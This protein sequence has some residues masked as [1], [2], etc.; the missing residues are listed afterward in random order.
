MSITETTF[1]WPDVTGP[2]ARAVY[3]A[4]ADICIKQQAVPWNI[5]IASSDPFA[6]VS[7]L[8]SADGALG[9]GDVDRVAAVLD[10]ADD[11]GESSNYTRQGASVLAGVPV[12][13]NVYTARVASVQS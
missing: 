1:L 9:I 4:I 7:V 8:I 5:D 2:E 13:L 12:T 11:N 10:L 6:H 3:A